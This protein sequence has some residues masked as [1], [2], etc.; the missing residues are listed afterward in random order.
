MIHNYLRPYVA[1]FIINEEKIKTKITHILCP[2]LVV[3]PPPSLR[4]NRIKLL[5]EKIKRGR[6][7]GEGRRREGEEK[8]EEW[9]GKGRGKK[10][11]GMEGEGKGNLV[12]N[13]P[14]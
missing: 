13:L 12:N 11:K 5:G 3:F 6:R 1:I 2:H 4:G 14:T 9:K 7:E 10:G 8:R